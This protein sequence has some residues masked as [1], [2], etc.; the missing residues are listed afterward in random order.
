MH[1]SANESILFRVH[2]PGSTPH[3]NENRL[4]A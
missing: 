2:S 4:S 1:D 3:V